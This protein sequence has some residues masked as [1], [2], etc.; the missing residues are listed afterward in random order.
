MTE[1]NKD[2]PDMAGSRSEF[3]DLIK[4]IGDRLAF[5]DP[6]NPP[7]KQPKNDATDPTRAVPQAFIDAM[8]VREEVFVREQKIPLENEL[9]EH[10]ARSFHWVAY[11]SIPTKAVSNSNGYDRRGSC[12]TKIPI[13]T[14]RLVPPPHP[15]HPGHEPSAQ[16]P[17]GNGEGKESYVKLGRLAVIKEFRKAG[18]SKL[19]IETALNYARDNPYEVGP[20]L[21]PASMEAA[22]RGTALNFKG[23]VVCHAQTGVQKVWRRHGFEVDASA[24]NWDEEGIDHVLMW[25]RMNVTDGRRKSKMWVTGH[26]ISPS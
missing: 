7:T 5:Y 18:I 23:L 17:G 4:P 13:G 11:A 10:D 6:T 24:G 2:Q 9:D 20:L 21:D 3:I 14:I 12:S 1:P 19:L 15:A 8:I 22:K 26:S 25:K 16:Q